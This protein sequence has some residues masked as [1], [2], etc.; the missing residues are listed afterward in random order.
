MILMSLKIAIITADKEISKFYKS[1]LK[2]LF[3]DTLDISTYST[4]DNSAFFPKTEEAFIVTN[5]SFNCHEKVMLTIPKEKPVIFGSV[6]IENKSVE[7]LKKYPNGTKALLVNTTAKMAVECISTLYQKGINNIEFYSYYPGCSE[8]YLNIEMAVTPAEQRFVPKNMKYI[9]DIGNRIFDIKTIIEIATVAKC[10]YLLE[11]ER[12]MEY[13]S[14]IS[15]NQIGI[16][17]LIEKTNTIR[18]QF[19]TFMHM[20]DV[21]II[22]IDGNGIIFICNKKAANLLC[23][24]Y[25][26]VLYKKINEFIAEDFLQQYREKKTALKITYKNNLGENLNISLSPVL[27]NDMYN[28]SLIVLN[29]E[30]ENEALQK[31]FSQQVIKKGHRARYT[32]EDIVGNS[33][34]IEKTKHI[35]SKMAKTDSTVLITGESGTGKELFAHSIHASSQRRNNPFV[36]INCAA[37]SDN[38]LESEIFGYEEGSFTGA[39]KGGKIGLFEIANNG[40]IF[41]DEIESMSKNLQVKLLRAIQEKE[42]MRV[43]GDRMIPINV[44]IIATSNENILKMI[45]EGTFR[46]DLYYRLNTL[47]ITIPPLRERKEDLFTLIEVFKKNLNCNFSLTEESK[48]IFNEYKWP[49]NIRELRNCIEYLHC[50][51]EKII[52]PYMLPNYMNVEQKNYNIFN[53]QSIL[54]EKVIYVMNELENQGRTCGR[55]A[56]IDYLKNENIIATEVQIKKV[57][58]NLNEKGYIKISKGRSG[59]KLTDL[60]KIKF[61]L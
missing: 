34:L 11:T 40:T 17:S 21:G 7:K 56:I 31:E 37:L 29:K 53:K 38:L 24:N 46:K 60:A 51:D 55:M 32:F 44:R 1:E 5:I 54:E 23:K 61:K 8:K 26:E 4:E 9:V 59:S 39:R 2:Y 45:E 58:K 33:F 49:G 12:F 35:A 47:P 16:E 42:I 48:A 27:N 10:E 6:T 28:S 19:N 30:S 57:F 25:S 50:L 41:L 14:R 43:G 18:K 15:E 52:E 20:L 36:A 13:F 3:G 22:G